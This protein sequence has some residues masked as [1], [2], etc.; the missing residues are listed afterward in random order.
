MTEYPDAVII[1][2]NASYSICTFPKISA[3]DI[4]VFDAGRVVLKGKT[5]EIQYGYENQK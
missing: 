2:K 4:L 3:A 5:Q 1:W